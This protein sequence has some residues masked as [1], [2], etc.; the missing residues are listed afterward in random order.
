MIDNIKGGFMATDHLIKR[1]GKDVA[2]LTGSLAISTY[3]DR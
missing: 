3:F 2:L 1:Y